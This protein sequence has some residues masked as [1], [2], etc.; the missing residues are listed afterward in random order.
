MLGMA[1]GKPTLDYAAGKRRRWWLLPV[2]VAAV[3]AVILLASLIGIF[4]AY[5]SGMN[6]DA[7]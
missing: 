2:I 3:I 1:D 5:F 6:H 7:P 4:G